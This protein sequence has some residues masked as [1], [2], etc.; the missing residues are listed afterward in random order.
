MLRTRALHLDDRPA[1]LLT[2]GEILVFSQ[3]IVG[4]DRDESWEEWFMEGDGLP[5]LCVFESTFQ[6]KMSQKLFRV[7]RNANRPSLEVNSRMK[8]C[9]LEFSGR[10]SRTTRELS[11]C[12]PAHRKQSE[13]CVFGMLR[14]S[15][16]L[17][18]PGQQSCPGHQSLS[19]PPKRSVRAAYGAK[20]SHDTEAPSPCLG[21]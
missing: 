6:R 10:F 15:C 7:S 1:R 18:P 13:A 19:K 2:R 21:R 12:A 4:T 20:I 14:A 9:R 17:R 5:A 16:G 8:P 3:R 11:G